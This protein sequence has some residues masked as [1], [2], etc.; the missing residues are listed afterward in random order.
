MAKHWDS[1]LS[2][3]LM[4]NGL[5]APGESLKAMVSRLHLEHGVQIR[6]TAGK[7]LV[8]ALAL[9]VYEGKFSELMLGFDPAELGR[10]DKN[11]R[12]SARSFAELYAPVMASELT[13]TCKYCGNTTGTVTQN[14][15]GLAIVFCSACNSTD[16]AD[17][18]IEQRSSATLLSDYESQQQS[19][20]FSG[21]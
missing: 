7:P 20:N 4:Q 12:I 17:T 21:N 10:S 5:A 2:V 11:E 3:H 14:H 6:T 8:G 13:E 1:A 16:F 15:A 18:A 19:Y 9:S